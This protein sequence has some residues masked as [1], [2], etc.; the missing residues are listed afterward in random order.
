MAWRGAIVVVLLLATG[1]GAA[2]YLWPFWRPSQTLELP[3]IVEIQ[4]VRLGSKIGGRVAEVLVR[5]GDIVEPGQLLVRFDVPE[6]E[7]QFK[8]QEGRLAAAEANLLKAK[9]G[10][11]P[12]EIRQT[13]SDLASQQADLQWAKNEFQRA[14]SL[15]KQNIFT[16][17]DY[18]NTRTA[19]D[20]AQG[21]VAATQALLDMLYEGTRKEDILLAEANVLEARGRLEELRSHLAEANVIAPE[22]ELVEVV[23]VRTGDLVPPN[24]P[25]IRVLRADDVW[26][27]VYVPE[28]ELGK[29]KLDQQVTVTCDAYPDRRF[30]GTVFQISSEAEFTP[31]NVQSLEERRYQVFGVKVR[32]D[33]PERVF[34]AG[35]SASVVFQF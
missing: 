24:T 1:C 12:E 2:A 4:E 22:R 16:D 23:S 27:K 25:V 31:R 5:E 34:K 30:T 7:A 29:V 33:D 17:A 9:N 11:R 14:E 3:G 35:M 32:V 8:Q 10:P 13:Q 28:T 15:F 21:R 26:V 18:E 6:L 20:R 19:R